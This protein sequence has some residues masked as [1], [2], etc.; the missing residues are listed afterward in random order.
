MRQIHYYLIISQGPL[1]SALL[2]Q[3]L[4]VQHMHVLGGHDHAM[5]WCFLACGSLTPVSAFIFIW[6]L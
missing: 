6:L 3:V 4:R 5:T 1:L 2:H